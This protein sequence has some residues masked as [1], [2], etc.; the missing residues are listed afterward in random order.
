MK[1]VFLGLTLAIGMIASGAHA[2]DNSSGGKMSMK[3]MTP[4]QRLEMASMHEKMAQCLRS[5]KPMEDCHKEMM[6]SCEEK[7]GQG[8]CPMMGHHDHKMMGHHGMD[9]TKTEK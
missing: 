6:K 3:S 4:E 1:N 5:D 8:A 9:E 2:G 7:M